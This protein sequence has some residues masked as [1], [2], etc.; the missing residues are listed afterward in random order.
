MEGPSWLFDD[1]EDD[2]AGRGQ[3]EVLR[4]AKSRSEK[5]QEHALKA[6]LSSASKRL[7]LEPHVDDSESEPEPQVEIQRPH[8]EPLVEHAHVD[9]PPPEEEPPR[10]G[11][12]AAAAAASKSL[13][14]Q[15]IN[16]KLRQGDPG[17]QSVYENFVPGT[18][19][20]SDRK[21]VK[22]KRKKSDNN[23]DSSAA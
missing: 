23:G 8:E 1:D 9:Q 21:S 17:S 3:S 10:R 2:V 22:N 15:P 13:K 5:R 14:E 16:T 19:R 20:K 4:R 7:T 18:K 11:R 6:R 12:R